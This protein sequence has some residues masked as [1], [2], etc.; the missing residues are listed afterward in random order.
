M[1]GHVYKIVNNINSDIYI[2]QGY[3]LNDLNISKINFSISIE[4]YFEKYLERCE[5]LGGSLT[6]LC[7]EIG[8]ILGNADSEFISILNKIGWLL[9]TAGQMVNDIA[10]FVILSE[11]Q[12][13]KNGYREQFNDIINGK[14]T[15]PLF[16]VLKNGKEFYKNRILEV[17]NGSRV[18]DLEEKK[19]LME[20]LVKSGA[21]S[22]TKMIILSYY[23]RL[24]KE[25]KKIP[26]SEARNLLSLSFSSLL[27]NK[28]FATI[29]ESC[30]SEK[31]NHL[32]RAAGSNDV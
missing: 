15:Y 17:L 14:V 9:G 3:D 23:K 24:K 21:I 32:C 7:L 29:R 1:I 31:Q 13:I 10:D 4:E 11:T 8:A 18:L 22:N 5:K 19:F 27:T 26:P 28:Y 2:G 16:Y 30:S 12:E 6:S 25:I 20:Y